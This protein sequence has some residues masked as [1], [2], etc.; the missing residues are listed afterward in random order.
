MEH[1]VNS[2]LL[3]AVPCTSFTLPLS[4]ISS[5]FVK[6]NIDF[7]WKGIPLK[8]TIYL[9]LLMPVIVFYESSVNTQ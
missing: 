3:A 6:P 5:G 1:S 8:S 9:E 2:S 7:I 4:S